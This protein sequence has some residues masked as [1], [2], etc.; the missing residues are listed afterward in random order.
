R[1]T[2]EQLARHYHTI[3]AV[4]AFPAEN[5]DSLS[6]QRR[7]SLDEEIHHAAAR[8]LHQHDSRN[9][10]LRRPA[11]HIAH[12]RRGQHL[13]I[14]RAI[15]MVISSDSSLEPVQSTTA[16]IVRAMSSLE[17]AD[18]YLAMYSISRSSPNLSPYAFSG[19]TIP[20]VYATRLPPRPSGM[21]RSS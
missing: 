5:H 11:I 18:E 19:S 13:H 17:S 16:S 21:V 4:V 9:A 14:R 2:R 8:I 6:A 3:A 12:F 7:K 10:G 20:S 15:A 1:E